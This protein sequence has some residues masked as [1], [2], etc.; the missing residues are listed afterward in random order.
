MQCAVGLIMEAQFESVGLLAEEGGQGIIVEFVGL[1][2][3]P[4]AW[5]LSGESCIS[6]EIPQARYR[7]CNTPTIL[8]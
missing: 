3:S 5:I 8:I 2:R 4:Q 1:G 7:I 6:E